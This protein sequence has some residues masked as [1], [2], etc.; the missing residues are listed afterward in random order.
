RIERGVIDRL[1]PEHDRELLRIPR[2]V[3]GDVDVLR[4]DVDLIRVEPAALVLL[5]LVRGEPPREIDL[6]LRPEG[7]EP[8]GEVRAVRDDRDPPLLDVEVRGLVAGAGRAPD[9]RAD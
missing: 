3:E 5:D 1:R 7:R 9:D 2:G 8:V 4:L 6:E